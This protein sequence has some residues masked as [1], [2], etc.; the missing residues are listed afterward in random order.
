MVLLN[1]PRYW[2]ID[3]VVK[4]ELID[5]SPKAFG[6]LTMRLA[7][8]IEL[9]LAEA[10]SIGG[11]YTTRTI[12]RE[13][14]VRF[15]AGKSVYE[16]IDPSGKIYNMQSYSI[17]QSPQ[18][19]ADLSTLGDRLALPAGWTYR[20]RVLKANLTITAVDNKATVIQDEFLNTYQLSQQ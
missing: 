3:A 11:A 14:V 5:E 7:G 6:A 16:L 20:T 1:G 8:R 4:G 10:S 12:Q 13:T 17:Q 2:T 19:L 15:D 9:P 18:T